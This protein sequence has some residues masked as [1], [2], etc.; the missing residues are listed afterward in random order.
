MIEDVP[1]T[2]KTQSNKPE[3]KGDPS[4]DSG[5]EGSSDSDGDEAEKAPPKPTRGRSSQVDKSKQG[6]ATKRARQQKGISCCCWEMAVIGRFPPLLALSTFPTLDRILGR[7]TP[8]SWAVFLPCCFHPT[9]IG[10]TSKKAKRTSDSEEEDSPRGKRAASAKPAK[11]AAKPSQPRAVRRGKAPKAGDD[12]DEE[13]GRR[14]SGR[15]QAESSDSDSGSDI[16]PPATRRRHRMLCDFR[17]RQGGDDED[18]SEESGESDEEEQGS[19]SSEEE[20]EEEEEEGGDEHKAESDD[21]VITIGSDEG[22]S[23]ST[24]SPPATRASPKGAVSLCASGREG[25]GVPLTG[26]TRLGPPPPPAV[27]SHVDIFSPLCH[28]T[29]RYR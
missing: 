15:G 26:A 10:P 9:T 24:P 25:L 7:L 2:K 28:F 11:P 17:G 4:D 14:R 16:E 12:E 23:R 5:S 29:M 13:T 18:G 22:E 3:K 21:N 27:P 20:E 19:D 1:K 8:F 6:G